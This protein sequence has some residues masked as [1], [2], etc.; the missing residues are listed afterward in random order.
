MYNSI[1]INL[2][3]ELNYLGKRT[4]IPK[5]ADKT[6]CCCDHDHFNTNDSYSY[7]PGEDC[8]SHKFNLKEDAQNAWC[9][10]RD[11]MMKNKMV[12]G[13]AASAILV[14]LGAITIIK[15]FS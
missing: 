8:C 7:S 3:K 12:I 14:T 11:F 13:I 6:S 4:K 9:P 10:V 2:Q 15:E 1:G 5:I